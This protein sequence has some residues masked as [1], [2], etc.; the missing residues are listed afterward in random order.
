M[1]KPK[2]I[3][4]TLINKIEAG[5]DGFGHPIYE[6]V[7]KEVD[8]VLVAPATTQEISDKLNL[9]GKKAVYNIAIP[10]GDTNVWEDQIVEFFG[11]TWQIVG[12]P[13]RGIDTNL[14]LDWNEIWMAAIY[15]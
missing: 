5:K 3:T 4:V 6:E 8:N 14:P 7:R 15:D 10:K 12:F 2:G 1:G 9:Y 13:K 11:H